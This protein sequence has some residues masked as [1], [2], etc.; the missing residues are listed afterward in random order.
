METTIGT[1]SDWIQ[2]GEKYALVGLSL[3]ADA[4]ILTGA[5]GATYAV[6]VD[7]ALKIPPYWREWL[8]TV[9]VED[10]EDCNIFLLTKCVST[11]PSIFNEEDK[12][13]RAR[14]DRFYVSLLLSCQ[15]V[16][17]HGA[18]VLS[19]AKHG[20]GIGVRQHVVK[21]AVAPGIVHFY[22]SLTSVQLRTAATLADRLEE[23]YANRSGSNWRLFRT[24]SL[25]VDGR[26]T[27][28]LMERIHLFCR[29]IDGLILPDIGKTKQQFKSRTELFIGPRHHDLMGQMYE[30]RS[31]AE[32]LHES[33]YLENF[34]RN[35][36][37]D[38]ARKD[39]VAEYMA[40]SA[41]SRILGN[42]DLR[43]HFANAPALASFWSLPTPE[44]RRLWGSEIN[45]LDAIRN[46]DETLVTD[47]ELGKP[48]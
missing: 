34:D 14:I 20:G 6:L 26:T 39:A 8:G 3:K 25:Y 24:L 5:L 40:Q 1:P 42:P 9:R 43:T 17:A 12:I 2:N 45:P 11:T 30:I 13:L 19:G 28:D 31:A 27:A 35:I 16:P 41:I 38:L 22:P 15:A 10:I 46:F 36:R 47:G 7:T 48:P 32:H 33:R 37:L 18:V 44:R 29:C 4:D 23:L 21:P